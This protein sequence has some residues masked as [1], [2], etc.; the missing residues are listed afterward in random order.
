MSSFIK[1]FTSNPSLPVLT[2]KG[3]VSAVDNPL[4]NKNIGA[5]NLAALKKSQPLTEQMS[6]EKV[7][8][9]EF[10]REPKPLELGLASS[11]LPSPESQL[12]GIA[13]NK[14]AMT[15]VPSTASN[16]A[17]IR[18]FENRMDK[19]L[20]DMQKTVP[21]F[22]SELPRMP[23]RADYETLQGYQKASEGYEG[24]FRSAAENAQAG[25]RKELNRKDFPSDQAFALAEQKQIEDDQAFTRDLTKRSMQA[26][27]HHDLMMSLIRNIA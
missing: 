15:G 14:S 4:L 27:A 16:D 7:A 20:K 23:R 11:A 6:P 19:L 10:Q 5:D 25:I 22:G 21:G 18:G 12:T 13:S 9:T 8:P 24:A 2:N 3:H 26:K 17:A 1:N